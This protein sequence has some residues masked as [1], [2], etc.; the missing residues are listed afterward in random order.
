M[1]RVITYLVLLVLIL[2]LSSC[3]D[4]ST[5][6]N[7]SS[8]LS[9]IDQEILN[10]V[11]IV[12]EAI[13]A[14][15]LVNCYMYPRDIGTDATQMGETLPE[16]LPEE[17]LMLNPITLAR[18]EPV[19]GAAFY[20]GGIGYVVVDALALPVGYHLTA[21]GESGER[22]YEH[23]STKVLDERRVLANAC[24]FMWAIWKFRSDNDG[25]YPRDLDRDENTNGK[26]VLD[27]LWIEHL[28]NPFTKELYRISYEY[29]ELPGE[30]GYIPIIKDGEV[31]GG[32]IIAIGNCP[33]KVIAE[34]NLNCVI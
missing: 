21:V 31:I 32:T 7:N 18:T 13:E 24:Y 30:I 12:Q 3:S 22:I 2:P 28:Y 25:K 4:D 10:N 20:P 15:R 9:E 23:Y 26:V 5:P 29:H 8:G 1:Y 27:D 6:V 19:N 17:R 16:L 11:M 34:Y 33:R 14:F